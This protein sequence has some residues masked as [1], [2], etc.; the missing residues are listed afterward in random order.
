MYAISYRATFQNG[1]RAIGFLSELARLTVCDTPTRRL[2]FSAGQDQT[3]TDDS[4]D[5]LRRIVEK[6]TLSLRDR[7]LLLS[8]VHATRYDY[9]EA[10]NE[11]NKSLSTDSLYV[12]ALLHRAMI[13]GRLSTGDAVESKERSGYLRLALGD[14][15]TA[16]GLTRETAYIDYNE[17]CILAL[18]GNEREALECFTRAINQDSRLAEAYYNR[19]LLRLRLGEKETAASDLSRAGQL[20][21]PKAY[22]RLKQMKEE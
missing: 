13:C 2:F 18:S 17:G 12:P 14:L 19:A 1:Y 6:Q 16:R 15:R 7:S 10:L 22:G 20:G 9:T 4:E 11:V 21:L 5:D 8:A 3:S